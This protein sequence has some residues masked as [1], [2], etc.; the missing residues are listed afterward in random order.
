ML[1]HGALGQYALGED[2]GGATTAVLSAASGSFVLIGSGAGALAE[3]FQIQEVAGSSSFVLT[4]EPA[5]F[6]PQLAGGF[7][8]FALTGGAATF[9][10]FLVESS[11]PF[12]LTGEAAVFG[13][14]LLA[15]S[16][17][18]DETGIAAVFETFLARTQWTGS[19]SLG[20]VL[21][22]GMSAL[23]DGAMELSGGTFPLLFTYALSGSP[24][25]SEAPGA[26]GRHRRQRG[27]SLRTGSR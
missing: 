10:A 20:G 18:L 25:S 16:G 24:I 9:E 8:S 6:Q 21:G 11:G 4:G 27:G 23:G 12:T 2:L 3:A 22:L 26:R 13:S 15:A 5:A 14:G 17:S 1:G 19:A 7:A